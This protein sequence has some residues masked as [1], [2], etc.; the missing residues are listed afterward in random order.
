MIGVIGATGK[1][2]APLAA[3]MADRGIDHVRLSSRGSGDRLLDWTDPTGWA[4]ALD[5][6]DAL[7]LVKPAH[8]TGMAERVDALLD[9]APALERVVLMSEMGREDKSDD[10]PDRAVERVVER[11]HGDW[12]IVR[13]SWFFQNFS[14]GGGY[15][16]DVMAGLISIPTGAAPISW[17]DTGDIAEVALAALTGPGHARRGYTLTGPEAFGVS[18]VAG[19]LSALLGRTVR[20]TDRLSA[21]QIDSALRGA[22][23]GTERH[24]YLVELHTDVLAG[25]YAPVTDDVEQVLGRPPRTFDDFARAHRADWR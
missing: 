1:T 24:A 11:W 21:D 23:G 4:A 22:A 25:V 12:T 16:G 17:I 20:T 2:G 15:C 10:D 18:E 8:D 9:S 6:V 5:G 14:A 19:R 3:L 13:P 7:Y